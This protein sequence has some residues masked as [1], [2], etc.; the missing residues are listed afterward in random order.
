MPDMKLRNLEE[1][2]FR[3]NSKYELALFDRLPAVQ[4][5]LLKD[6]Q[7]DPN[8][9][10]I[11]RPRESGV[12]GIK[13]VCRATALLYLTLQEPGRLPAYVKADYAE[14]VHDSIAQLVLDG[15]L[16][17]ETQGRFVS[18]AAAYEI[19][20]GDGESSAT[21]VGR[22]AQL[23]IEALKY[24]QALDLND[25][26][27]LSERLYLYNRQPVSPEWKRRLPTPQALQDFLGI[28]NG[29]LKK[30][31]ARHWTK[32]PSAGLHDPWLAWN[33]RRPAN[34]LP[35]SG[36]SYKLYVSPRGECAREAF[37][38]MVEVLSDL[39]APHFKI[40]NDVYGL[41]RPDKFVAYFGDYEALHNA[42]ARLS[43]RLDNCPAHGVP[44][45]AE[46]TRDGLL[47][48]GADPPERTHAPA[49][50]GSESWRQWLTN[51]LATALLTA[52]AT[53]ST[54]VEPWQFALERLRFEGVNTDSWIPSETI[55]RELLIEER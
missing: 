10:G 27:Q 9:Y 50:R 18:G 42:A 52:K 26:V 47:S 39:R 41:L 45:S 29:G 13:A 16:E 38:I 24:A 54:T 17:I 4:Q 43:S 37:Q 40:G 55:W 15:I 25:A 32:V 1:A 22:I 8:L 21:A 49:W 7:K 2:N 14:R 5:E 34:T 35:V 23:S 20:Y 46:I 44:F 48:W 31:L 12:T 19:I 36:I 30:L 28:E 3:A 33:S 6:L 51:R 11:L 53:C